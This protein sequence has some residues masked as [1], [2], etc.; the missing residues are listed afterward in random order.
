MVRDRR[1]GHTTDL[2]EIPQPLDPL[3]GS[4]E[5][6]AELCGVLSAVIKQSPLSRAQIAAAM[7]DLT[8][9]RISDDMLNAWTSRAHDRHR[10]PFEFAAAFEA[11]TQTTALQELIARKRGTKVFAGREV[12]EAEVGRVRRQ[13]DELSQRERGLMKLLK[14]AR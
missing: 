14:D 10:F 8:G 13:K 1:D 11:A 9:E 2:F 6:A 12:I 7:S 4:L 5:Y 3:P